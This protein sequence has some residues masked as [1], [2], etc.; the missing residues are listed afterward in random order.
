MQ[1]YNCMQNKQYYI[2]SELSKLLSNDL[3]S[4]SIFKIT[5]PSASFGL[6]ILFH[7]PKMWLIR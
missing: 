7:A 2:W 5:S 1:C 6:V 3:E 4:F